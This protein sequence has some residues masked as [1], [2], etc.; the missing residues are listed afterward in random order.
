MENPTEILLNIPTPLDREVTSQMIIEFLSQPQIEAIN[1]KLNQEKGWRIVVSSSSE[2]G[3]ALLSGGRMLDEVRIYQNL[4]ESDST[5]SWALQRGNIGKF[6][7]E[8]AQVL[9]QEV[10]PALLDFV[11]GYGNLGARVRRLIK[12]G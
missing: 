5:Y 7:P 8:A 10:V 6:N 4:V 3:I 12:R 11:A 1:E 2:P 9:E